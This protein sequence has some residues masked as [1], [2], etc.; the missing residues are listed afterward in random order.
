VPR[1]GGALFEPDK[2]G[3]AEWQARQDRLQPRI[4]RTRARKAAPHLDR[5]AEQLLPW[6]DRP[7]ASPNIRC[8]TEQKYSVVTDLGNALTMPW[9]MWDSWDCRTVIAV[10]ADHPDALDRAAEL[11]RR[12][13]LPMPIV[14]ADPYTGRSHV[15]WLLLTPV[16]VSA[17]A[18]S[19]PLR[20]FEVAGQMLAR[21]MGGSLMPHRALVKSPWG[22]ATRL[23]GD[24]MHRDGG[25]GTPAVWEAY[26]ASGSPLV[27]VTY[28]GDLRAVD[29]GEVIRA[30]DGEHGEPADP[31]VVTPQAKPARK[32]KRAVDAAE[33]GEEGRNCYVF[34][35]VR[36]WAQANHERDG[37][38]IRDKTAEVNRSL[39]EPL[40][41]RE[42][43]GVA[44]SITRYRQRHFGSGE[45][46][47]EWQA[48]RG[49]QARASVAAKNGA[50]VQQAIEKLT[51]SGAKPTQAAVIEET[52]LSRSTVVRHWAQLR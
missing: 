39:P 45:V 49:R 6:L 1:D 31:P 33:D 30:L 28:P 40:S 50:T 10:D 35:V 25:P 19:G 9:M 13:G 2:N 17:R 8:L 21:A 44:R 47:R 20:L 41:D 51:K 3:F 12:T 5:L 16:H 4:A 46:A 32:P 38:A 27:W 43:A 29:L 7:L 37:R 36:L 23:Q 34:E 18:K 14:V 11:S 48:Y 24:L 22:L 15:G 42:A 26:V 52:G